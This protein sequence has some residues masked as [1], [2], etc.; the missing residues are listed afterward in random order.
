MRRYIVLLLITG[1]VWA[2]TG[3][4]KLVLKDGTYYKGK[5]VY[6]DN[7]ITYFE[8]Q[9]VLDAKK[10]AKHWIAYPLLAGLTFVSSIYGTL[11]IARQ[12]PW[13]SLPAMI[14]I[15]IASLALPY[16]SLNNSDK[17]QIEKL[18]KQDYDIKLYKETF[19]EEFIKNNIIGFGLLGFAAAG[20]Y[21]YVVSNL[22]DLSPRLGY[23]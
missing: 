12:E 7:K 23:F 21:S 20:G 1:T 11:I 17:N 22:T 16:I 5:Y 10:D 4:D 6:I 3:L 15:S 8:P 13:E 14:G 2:Q 19:S 18:N 9:E